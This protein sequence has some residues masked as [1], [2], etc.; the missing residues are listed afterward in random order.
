MTGSGSAKT[1]H[2]FSSAERVLAADPARVWMLVADPSRAG[3]WAAAATVGYMGTELPKQGQV[4]FVRTRRWQRPSAARRVEVEEWEAGSRYRCALQPTRM[5]PEATLE[6][7]IHPE[8]TGESVATRIRLVQRMEARSQ[9][10]TAVQWVV[11][12][13]LARLLDRIERA[14]R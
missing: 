9:A 5:V 11:D 4:I 6:V 12:R 14:T 8:P 2:V 10:A 13:K 3:E 1:V 7:E